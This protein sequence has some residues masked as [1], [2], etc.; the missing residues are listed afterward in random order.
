MLMYLVACTV[1]VLLDMASTYYVQYKSM[2]GLDFRDYFGKKIEDYDT[3]TETFETYAMQRSLAENVKLYAFPSTFL[4]PFLIEPFVTIY[5]P[6]KLG[7]LIVRTHREIQGRLAESYYELCVFDLGRYADILLN[8]FLGIL[9]FWFPGGYIRILFY[10]MAG[11]HLWIYCFDHYKV[12]HCIPLTKIVNKGVDDWAQVMM[13]G[14]CGM[15]LSALVFKSNCEPYNFHGYCLQGYDLIYA[16]VFA[17]VSHFI[18]HCFLLGTLVPLL[19]GKIE[20][21]RLEKEDPSIQ[22]AIDKVTFKECA[23]AEAFSWFSSNPVHCLRSKFL[24]KNTPHC[25]FVSPGKEHFLELNPSINC[26]FESAEAEVEDFDEGDNVRNLG[27][28][29]KRGVTETFNKLKRASHGSLDAAAAQAQADH[30]KNVG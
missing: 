24:H 6:L 16:T 29:L 14:L 25:R 30:A 18:L 5:V 27:E 8:V 21:K 9:V 26:Y 3:F 15:I 23:E 10:G 4:I 11:S 1:N 7:H 22:Q 19:G 28:T 17:G 20:A 2:V 13:A 12:L